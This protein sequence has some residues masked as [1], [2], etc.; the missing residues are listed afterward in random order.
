MKEPRV[1]RAESC[2]G[3]PPGTNAKSRWRRF[4]CLMKDVGSGEEM[5]HSQKPRPNAYGMHA[6]D[7]LENSVLAEVAA[8]IFGGC[9]S[10]FSDVLESFIFRFGRIASLG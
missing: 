4:G 1:K 3:P 9:R 2:P 6:V 5:N 8:L 7:E 10:G